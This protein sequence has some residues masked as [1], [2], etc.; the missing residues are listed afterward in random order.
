MNLHALTCENVRASF[1]RWGLPPHTRLWNRH[2][3]EGKCRSLT[4]CIHARLTLV[5]P[6]VYMYICI[7]WYAYI[8]LYQFTRWF[9]LPLP[10]FHFRFSFRPHF[11]VPLV[12]ICDFYRAKV[13]WARN[14]ANTGVPPIGGKLV[15]TLRNHRLRF[16]ENFSDQL[17]ALV[18]PAPRLYHAHKRF[19]MTVTPEW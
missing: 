5:H 8:R 10:I 2:T 14:T 9:T 3:P 7:Y 13:S 18:P 17:S 6:C 4:P 12:I 19:E 15:M 1:L 16:P 11:S